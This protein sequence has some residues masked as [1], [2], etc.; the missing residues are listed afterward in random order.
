[1]EIKIMS[2]YDAFEYVINH[3]APFDND[4]ELL[5]KDNYVVISIQDARSNGFGFE[6]AKSKYC[7]D[8]LTLK[9]D[10][11]FKKTKDYVLFDETMADSVID[12]LEK[13]DGKV[14][15]LLI[16]CYAGLSRSAAIGAFARYFIGIENTDSAN[17]G[18]ATVYKTLMKQ[19]K[20][21]ASN[22]L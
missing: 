22:V 20:K 18:N 11:I 3:Y 7:K 19:H 4:D 15:T 1:M 8:V 12:F 10:D 13:W 2:V 6:F 14:D 17:I 16:H 21:R 9:F 5:F